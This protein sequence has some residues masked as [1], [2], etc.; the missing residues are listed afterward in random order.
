[1]YAEFYTFYIKLRNRYLACSLYQCL[2]VFKNRIGH[3][4]RIVYTPYLY[5]YI[6]KHF[7]Y[8]QVLLYRRNA[9]DTHTS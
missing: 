5:H 4:E 3:S 6:I 9:V 8:A 1:M 7:M 2:L